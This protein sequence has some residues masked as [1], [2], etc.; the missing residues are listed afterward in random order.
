MKLWAMR[1]SVCCEGGRESE[2]GEDVLVITDAEIWEGGK[3]ERERERGSERCREGQHGRQG[4]RNVRKAATKRRWERLSTA[5]GGRARASSYT[6]EE[7]RSSHIPRCQLA[8][9]LLGIALFASS[10]LCC[11]VPFDVPQVK[12]P[13][14]SLLLGLFYGASFGVPETSCKVHSLFLLLPLVY[15]ARFL[16]VS[17]SEYEMLSIMFLCLLALIVVSRFL[18]VTFGMNE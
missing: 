16:A 11:C 1:K 10:H 2:M 4:L 5:D 13:S 18:W 9:A 3:A 17:K 15:G 7:A 14:Q 6:R 8:A 12:S